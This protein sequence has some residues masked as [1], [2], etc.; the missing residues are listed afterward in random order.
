MPS[1]RFFV[2]NVFPAA[3]TVLVDDRGRALSTYSTS[4]CSLVCQFI[5]RVRA[6]PARQEQ[7]DNSTGSRPPGPA[8]RPARSALGRG[9]V[10]TFEVDPVSR[11]AGEDGDKL[12]GAGDGDGDD[13]AVSGGPTAMAAA[14]VLDDVAGWS[15]A[16]RTYTNEG[17]SNLEARLSSLLFAPS[18][19]RRR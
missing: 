17:T 12:V 6:A 11:D 5:K 15:V 18:I 16:T 7:L 1:T 14:L 13:Q 10:P 3:V 9:A 4:S 19:A 8:A 2:R